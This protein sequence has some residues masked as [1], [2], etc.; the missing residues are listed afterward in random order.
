M[1][2]MFVGCIVLDHSLRYVASVAVLFTFYAIVLRCNIEV[3]VVLIRRLQNGTKLN[4][5]HS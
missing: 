3:D 2:R 4:W 5:N 1:L